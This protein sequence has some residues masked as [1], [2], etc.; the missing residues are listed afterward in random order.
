MT[1][2]WIGVGANLGDARATVVNA[3]GE[4]A[5]SPGCKLLDISGLYRSA[6]IDAGGDDYIN[7]V[8]RIDSA[9]PAFELLQAL[10]AIEQE[11]GR[12]RPYHN[13]P[14]TLDLDL[15]LYGDETADTPALRLPHP[16]LHQRAFVLL[17]LLELAP[18]IELP[19]LGPASAFLDGVA[20]QIIARID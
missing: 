1:I 10:H 3:L 16:R 20:N 5:A 17:P 6:P 13:A 18:A 11:H 8:V 19:G 2:A 7:A 12:E 15:L 4:L 9:L 14:R